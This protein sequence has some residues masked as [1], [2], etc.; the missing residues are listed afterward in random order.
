MKTEN[1]LPSM[2]NKIFRKNSFEVETSF[3]GSLCAMDGILEKD[4]SVNE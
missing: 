2:K 3:S 1:A 4:L